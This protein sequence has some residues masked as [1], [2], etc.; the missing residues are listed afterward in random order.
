ME[1]PTTPAARC[2]HPIDQ[3]PRLSPPLSH[4]GSSNKNWPTCQLRK[5]VLLSCFFPNPFSLQSIHSSTSVPGIRIDISA[6]FHLLLYVSTCLIPPFFRK[7]P[8]VESLQWRKLSRVRSPLTSVRATR[9]RAAARTMALRSAITA[10]LAATWYVFYF[11]VFFRLC[12]DATRLVVLPPL[13]GLHANLQRAPRG[14][15]PV[16]HVQALPITAQTP[17]YSLFPRDRPMLDM[18]PLA[19]FALFSSSS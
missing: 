9:T 16:C 7:P 5:S 15:L 6:V 18:P 12:F 8:P 10:R 13:Q 11:C 4:W 1:A 2:A 14:E 19:R 17:P 3:E